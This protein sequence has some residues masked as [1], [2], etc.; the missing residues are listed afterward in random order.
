MIHKRIVKKRKPITRRDAIRMAVKRYIYNNPEE[1]MKVVELNRQRRASLVDSKYGQTVIDKGDRRIDKNSPT[2][3]AFCFPEKLYDL[4]NTIIDRAGNEPF[5]QSK[6]E[7]R[8]F[9]QEFPQF[10]M[11]DRGYEVGKFNTHNG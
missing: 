6:E 10:S 2:R 1:Y 7:E 3:L 4:F 8:W 9:T 11:S 5:L